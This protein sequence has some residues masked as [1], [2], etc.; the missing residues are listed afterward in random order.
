MHSTDNTCQKHIRKLDA[1][2]ETMLT[3]GSPD[4]RCLRSAAGHIQTGNG[5]PTCRMEYSVVTGKEARATTVDAQMSA[6]RYYK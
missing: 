3:I 2:T 5:A 4:S 6:A 1:E